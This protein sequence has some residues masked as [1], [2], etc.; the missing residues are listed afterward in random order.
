ME[1]KSFVRDYLDFD[2]EYIDS[3]ANKCAELTFGLPGA[4]GT[5]PFG[6]DDFFNMVNDVLYKE[7]VSPD[8]EAC[9]ETINQCFTSAVETIVNGVLQQKG[10]E[11]YQRELDEIV[12]FSSRVY[13]DMIFIKTNFLTTNTSSGYKVR[14]NEDMQMFAEAISSKMIPILQE[15]KEIFRERYE[16]TVYRHYTQLD[17]VDVIAEFKIPVEDIAQL[18]PS[19]IHQYIDRTC[20]DKISEMSIDELENK[21][22]S[23]VSNE[24]PVALK[25]K[26][27]FE[28]ENFVQTYIFD[29]NGIDSYA[30]KI[31]G[32][33]EGLVG[34]DGSSAFTKQ[35]FFADAADRF[36]SGYNSINTIKHVLKKEF[37]N[38][39]ECALVGALKEKYDFLGLDNIVSIS[40]L[41]DT[42]AIYLNAMFNDG[43]PPIK[44]SIM[45]KADV[46]TFVQITADKI[47]GI[48]KNTYTAELIEKF[49]N[50]SLKESLSIV[51][52]SLDNVICMSPDKIDSYVQEL[53]AE[54]IRSMTFEDMKETY[55]KMCK[56][57]RNNKKQEIS[58]E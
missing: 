10:Y 34:E 38:Y 46:M 26:G 49:R 45:S 30:N 40:V 33:V 37:A 22:L 56:P 4:D 43:R 18:K 28:K 29:V 17:I 48:D 8:Y 27:E 44:Q 20:N 19:E 54:K 13:S 39:V 42:G 5:T 50:L 57:Q 15:N 41:K 9:V 53:F 55:R 23:I 11:L 12:S 31:A 7:Y 47:T 32:L 51:G 21:Y 35:D 14:T 52:E 25:P 6:Q 2:V 24:T 1:E 36:Q 3:L 58:L 16:E